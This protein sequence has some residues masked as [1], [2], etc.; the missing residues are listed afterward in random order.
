MHWFTHITNAQM[1]I[2][3]RD[4]EAIAA[5]EYGTLEDW[6]FESAEYFTKMNCELNM[7]FAAIIASDAVYNMRNN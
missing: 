6:A 4:Y 1:N 7:V 3:Y 5:L 2:D